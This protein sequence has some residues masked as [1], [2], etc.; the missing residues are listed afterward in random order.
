MILTFTPNPSNDA[1]LGLSEPLTRGAVLRPTNV[2]R[3]AGGKGVNVAHALFLS[4][5]DSLALFP[6][7]KNDPFIALTTTIGMKFE[8]I[9]IEGNVRT[10]TAITEPDG[11]T[12]KLNE[13]GP[14]FLQR[15]CVRLSVDSES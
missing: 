14:S 12:T 3:N 7:A 13:P 8:A 6:A 5:V 1:T 2:Q 15:M 10:N 4:E 11:T 9:P